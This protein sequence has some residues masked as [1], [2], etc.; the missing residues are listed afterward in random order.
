MKKWDD[1]PEFMKKEEIRPYYDILSKKKTS[2]FFK[3][4]FDIIVSFLLLVILFPL[5]LVLAIAIKIDSPGPVFYRQERVTTYGKI[6]RIH[7]FRSMYDGADKKGALVTVSNDSRVTRVGR[8]IRNYRLDEIAQLIDVLT[9]NMTFVGVR[10][11]VVK[12]VKKYRPEWNATFLIPAGVTNLT[13]I[14]H[15]DDDDLLN[16]A[17]DPD[18]FYVENI[19]PGKMIC[20]LKG[21]ERFSFFGDIKIMFMTFFTVLG[22]EYKEEK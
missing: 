10:P 14:Y 13:S 5:I 3:R 22:K 21:L 12:Y 8:I 7:K 17:D 2:L 9:G 20:N 16:G 1:L 15:K 4:V 6:F 18:L 19:L 11:E